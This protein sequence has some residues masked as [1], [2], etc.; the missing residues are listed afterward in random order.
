MGEFLI[1]TIDKT[2]QHQNT[3]REY[4]REIREE[5]FLTF[6]AKVSE[7]RHLD[8]SCFIFGMGKHPKST[9]RTLQHIPGI[10]VIWYG[11]LLPWY[12]GLFRVAIASY[13]GI[14]KVSEPK[15]IKGTFERLSRMSMVG[16]YFFDKRLEDAF[17]ETVKTRKFSYYADDLVKQDSGYLIYQV[18]ADSLESSTGIFEIVSYGKTCPKALIELL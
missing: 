15:L 11:S 1:K 14:V 10:E 6:L 13:E 3:L 7:N 4:S 9:Y 16:L 8:K 5:E 17:I 12:L 18:D 2:P